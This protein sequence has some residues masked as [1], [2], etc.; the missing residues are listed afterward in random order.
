MKNKPDM[1]FECVSCSR[2]VSFSITDMK[3]QQERGLIELLCGG[4]GKKFVF[5]AKLSDQLQRFHALILAVQNAKDII[6]NIHVGI[7]VGDRSVKIPYR[8]LLTRMNP[9]V[10][11]DIGGQETH[12]KFRVEPLDE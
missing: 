3:G 8:L 11:L 2:P 7:E 5:D 12:F 6:G 1:E 9:T 10:R 4:C